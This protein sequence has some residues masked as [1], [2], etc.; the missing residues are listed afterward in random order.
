MKNIRMTFLTFVLMAMSMLTACN[1]GLEAVDLGLPSGTK[2]A[3][4]NVGAKSPADYG[5]YFAWGETTPKRE[6]YQ[7]NSSTYGKQELNSSVSGNPKYDAATANWGN[8]WK[9]PTE[10]Q[11]VEL[12]KK[13]K[14]KRTTQ[15]NSEGKMVKGYKV[16]G[17]NGNSIFLPAAGYYDGSDLLGN[18]SKGYYWSSTPVE[19]FSTGAY[20]LDFDS[21]ER[22]VTG[23]D[24][25]HSRPRG[26]S[27]RPVLA[28]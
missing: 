23:I 3:S 26:Q 5:D 10:K 20:F 18:G 22:N 13:C 1:N 28:E 19:G 11:M 21:E 17:R 9:L 15:K 16:T 14:W 6:Y 8:Q 12:M 2:W 25:L 4:V 24:R 27:I 7:E